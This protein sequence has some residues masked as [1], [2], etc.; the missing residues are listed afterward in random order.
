MFILYRTGSRG[1]K[2][3][4][5]LNIC[6]C[7]LSGWVDRPVVRPDLGVLPHPVPLHRLP[8]ARP[9]RHHS[10]ETTDLG[11]TSGV[12]LVRVADSCQVTT[13][14]AHLWDGHLHVLAFYY[15]CS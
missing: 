15:L 11:A 1:K 9:P 2:G 12:D 4:L 5:L 10:G 13:A 8:R 7:A 3:K 14:E 6:C